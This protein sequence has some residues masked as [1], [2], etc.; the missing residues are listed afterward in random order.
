MLGYPAYD[1][2]KQE[3]SKLIKQISEKID[4][5]KYNPALLSYDYDK[6]LNH[7]LTILVEGAI[8]FENNPKVKYNIIPATVWQ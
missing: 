7:I 1:Y 5:E 2:M 6:F 3:T 8:K 4:K